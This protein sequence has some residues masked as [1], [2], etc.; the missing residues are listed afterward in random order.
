MV[1]AAARDA[2]RR[3]RRAKLPARAAP[4]RVL[5]PVGGAGAQKKFITDLVV[6]A[7]PAAHRGDLQLLLNAGDHADMRASLLATLDGLGFSTENPTD[8]QVFSTYDDVLNLAAELKRGDKT[9]AKVSLLAFD[10]YFAA[11]AATDLLVPSVD[12]LACKPSELAF[13]PVPKLMIRRVGD[14]EAFSANRANELGDGT[15]E[16]RTVEEALHYLDL[17]VNHAEPLVSMNEMI[18]LHVAN[19][20]Y[21][22]CKTALALAAP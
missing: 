16:A 11:V 15:A 12:V 9:G 4:R 10:D 13:Y 5:V 6:A 19:G 1:E 8:L 22:G 14:H 18:K 2:D 7:A 20:A 21:D 3:A 17:F